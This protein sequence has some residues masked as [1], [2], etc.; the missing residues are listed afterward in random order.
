MIQAGVLIE[1]SNQD[2]KGKCH[3]I[4]ISRTQSLV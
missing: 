3:I 4:A 2:S 1:S